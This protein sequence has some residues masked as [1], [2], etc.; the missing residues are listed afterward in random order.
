MQDQALISLAERINQGR[1]D[2]IREEELAALLMR[3]GRLDVEKKMAKLLV[4]LETETPSGRMSLVRRRLA[5]QRGLDQARRERARTRAEDQ[6]RLL[7]K[8]GLEIGE[9]PDVTAVPEYGEKLRQGLGIET[10]H[11]QMRHAEQYVMDPSQYTARERQLVALASSAAKLFGLEQV[12]LVRHEVQFAG[13][14][15]RDYQ[16]KSTMFLNQAQVFNLGRADPRFGTIDKATDTLDHELGHFIDGGRPEAYVAHGATL[17]H[18]AVGTFA[19]AMKY[20]AAIWLAH[21]EPPPAAPVEPP[22]PPV[23]PPEGPTAPPAAPSITDRQGRLLQLIDRT[24][25]MP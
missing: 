23:S 2:A 4:L 8:A 13:A 9:I 21:H 17:S 19:E 24:E 11:E 10:A 16:G 3:P 5:V 18:D 14:F 20:I 6:L 25:R 12:L 1:Y 7:R 15:R 22:T